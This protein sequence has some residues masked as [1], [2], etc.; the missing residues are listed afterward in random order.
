MS[1]GEIDPRIPRVALVTGGG[2]RIG[3][4]IALALG[5]DG[6]NVAVHYHGSAT[7][8][9]DVVETIQASGGRAVALP[10]DLAQEEQV[11]TLIARAAAVLGPI[12]CLINNASTFENDTAETA[13][14]ESWD[15]HMGPNLR[16]PFV[17]SQHLEQ[18]LP[19]DACGVI[20]NMLDQRVWNLTPYFISYTLSKAGLW[21]LTQDAGS[22][23]GATHPRQC[24]GSGSRPPQQAADH[25]TV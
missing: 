2:K 14:R 1:S 19:A 5:A 22:G 25:G 11:E 21:T 8:A 18:A 20:I 24:R 9:Q 16:A 13:T 23:L 15:H 12:G 17:L 3:R 6:W 4:A 7:E 10:A